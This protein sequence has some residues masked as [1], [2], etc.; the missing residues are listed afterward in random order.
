MIYRYGGSYR[1]NTQLKAILFL[2]EELFDMISFG[3]FK[4]LKFCMAS[5]PQKRN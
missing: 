4:S 5:Y 1:T 2:F 3:C